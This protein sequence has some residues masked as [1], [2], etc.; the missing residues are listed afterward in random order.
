MLL[1]HNLQPKACKMNIIPNLH[2]TLISVPKMADADYIA[3][4]NKKEA[5]IYNAT[6]TIISASE[7]PI[8][9]APCCQDTGL[10][11]L[12]LDYEVL[13]R[14]YPEQFIVGAYK[15]NTIFNLPNTQQSPLYH[16]ALAGFPPKETFLAAVRA[17]NYATW[18]GLT[19]TIIHKHFPHSNKTQKGHMKGQR[20]GVRST[21]VSA[22]VTIKVE[23]GTANPS[24]PTITKHYNIFVVTYKLL[25]TVHTD[26]TSPFPITSQQGYQYIMVGIHLDANYIFCELMK[27][28]TKGKMM[29]AYQKMVDRMKV[30]ALGLKH[31]RLDNECSSALKA[32]IA[33]NRMTH[34]LVP[35]DCHH[36]NIT[37]QAIKTFKNH[38]V[39]ILS[40]V[41]NRFPLSLWC[42]LVQPTELTINLLQQSNVAPKVSVYAHVHGQHNYMKCPFAPLG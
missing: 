16:H 1:K 6:T 37:K 36:C 9:V 13:C 21:K 4:F 5:R 20:K 41:D 23:P 2:S 15:A 14:E 35:L 8:L 32:C 12:D 38:F 7:D 17:G 39:S 42:H 22:P 40:G 3:V 27:N 26:Q 10:W 19:T 34:K 24:P 18:P 29:M 25:D 11:K 31:H 33:K 28:Q 30:S